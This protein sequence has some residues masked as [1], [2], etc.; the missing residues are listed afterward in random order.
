[1]DIF[2]N[3]QIFLETKM[4]QSKNP[5]KTTLSAKKHNKPGKNRSLKSNVL[6]ISKK[7][8]K[9]LHKIYDTSRAVTSRTVTSRAVTSRTIKIRKDTNK[10][11]N[12]PSNRIVA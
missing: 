12:L 5:I 4:T 8:N 7:H 9:Q 10:I 3:P 11:H 2:N 1:M 6:Q